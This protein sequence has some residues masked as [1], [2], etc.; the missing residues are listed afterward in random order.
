MA[1]EE[2]MK[3]CET[4]SLT[5]DDG[6]ILKIDGEVHDEGIRSVTH[7]LVGKILSRKKINRDAFRSAIEQIW[8]TV[9]TVDIK[10]LA[11][12]VFIFHFCS[13]EDLEKIRGSR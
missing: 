7:C 5:E 8:S 9:S 3:L 1:T 10:V 11:D 12:N 2:I 13:L 4:L 6:L